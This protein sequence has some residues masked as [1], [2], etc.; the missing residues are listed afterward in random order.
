MEKSQRSSGLLLHP[1]SLPGPYGIG[2]LGE[3][4][5]RFVDFLADSRQSLWQI[6]PLVP[7][8][9]GNSPYQSPS[10]FAGNPL[11]IDPDVLLRERYL[12][13]EDL[14]PLPV[15]P[16]DRVDYEAAGR[17]KERVLGAA[18][19]TFRTAPPDGAREAF[20][21]FSAENA[22]WLDDYALYSALR[23]AF[24]SA[25]RE[26]GWSGWPEELVRRKPQALRAWQERLAEEVLE[27]QF[28]QFLFYGQWAE[29][30][31]YAN[32]KGV[33]IVGDIPIFVSYDSAEV[34]AHPELFQ[35]RQ[36]RSPRVVAGVPP[37][38]FSETGQL[39]GN[40]L[41]N[42][43]RMRSDGFAWWVARLRHML[44]LVDIVRIDHFRGF[45]A[46][47][48]IPAEEK[49]AVKGRWIETPGMEFFR[50]AERELG[51]LPIIAEDLGLITP[52]V[53][54]LR[55][56]LGFP[57]MKV[58]QFAFGEDE[59]NP[60]LPHNYEPRCA[61]YTGTHDNN[62]TIGWYRSLPEGTRDHVRR[63]LARDGHDVAWDFIRLAW[64]SVAG[65]ALTTPQDL[66]GLGEEGR[67]NLPSTPSGNW[68]WRLGERRLTPDMAGRLRELTMLYRRDRLR[69]EEWRGREAQSRERQRKEKRQAARKEA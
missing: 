34:W 38:Y 52:E 19:R 62:T 65:M 17:Y 24:A 43:E 46:S 6:L 40:P 68:G 54:A 4:A 1:T 15:F 33:R 20:E 31:R 66:L 36:D 42:W 67:M 41:Y 29:V 21:A 18:F 3:E 30:K 5:C 13:K 9:Y 58:L 12:R 39:W 45:Q 2:G 69:E 23:A 56:L 37:D 26:G 55:E 47:W 49:T 25:G 10:S 27:Q 11:L 61:V 8:G 48:E 44:R 7:V 14:Q 32:E 51:R 53:H 16:S 57:G 60:Y 28:R 63:Y 35:L 50:A 59:F 64:S 22:G